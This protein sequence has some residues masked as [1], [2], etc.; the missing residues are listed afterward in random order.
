MADATRVLEEAVDEAAVLISS[1]PAEQ[2]DADF[3][4]GRI[5]PLVELAQKARLAGPGTI[6]DVEVKASALHPQK[7]TFLTQGYP[8]EKK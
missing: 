7:I 3:Y 4:E 8:G 1:T 2:R 6:S 5:K